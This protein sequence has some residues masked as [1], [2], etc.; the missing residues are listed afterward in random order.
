MWKCKKS[1]EEVQKLFNEYKSKYI[2]QYDEYMSNFILNNFY[3]YIGQ[4]QVYADL[5]E[6]YSDFGMI[7]DEDNH[8]VAYLDKIKNNF[9]LDR[10]ILEVASGPLPALANMIAKE[11]L[12]L[13][14][15]TITVYD[16]KLIYTNSKYENMKLYKDNFSSEVDVSCFDL[17]ISIMPCTV[18][19]DVLESIFKNNKDYFVAFCG[20]DHYP[21]FNPYYMYNIPNPS[22][23]YYLRDAKEYNEKYNLGEL[24][25]DELDEKFQIP[26]PIIYNKR[27]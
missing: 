18:T 5:L 9:S 8:Y 14:N 7:S 25:E 23:F 6:I 3:E 13:G 2:D 10:N 26:Y 1:D 27:K 24:I 19:E 20:C 21:D 17:I 11:Q 4:R 12:K 16:P 15:G 22:Y